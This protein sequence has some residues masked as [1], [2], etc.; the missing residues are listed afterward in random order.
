LAGSGSIPLRPEERAF[1]LL[2]QPAK[3]CLEA[4]IGLDPRDRVERVA[5]LVMSPR[6]V[7]KIFA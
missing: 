6:L 2:V 1:L 4:R 7:N 3:E 5:Q